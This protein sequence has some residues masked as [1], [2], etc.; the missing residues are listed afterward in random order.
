MNSKRILLLSLSPPKSGTE[1]QLHKIALFLKSEGFHVGIISSK[2]IH[3]FGL[4]PSEKGIET[5]FLNSWIRHPFSNLWKL[6][7]AIKT[8]RPDVVLAFMFI[9][10]IVARLMKI[11]LRF[12]LI[13]TIRMSVINRKWYLPFIMTSRLDDAV[14]YNSKASKYNFERKKLVKKRGTVIHNGVQLP[15]LKPFF[16]TERV[17]FTWV[18]IGHFR[19][20]KDYETL[21]KAMLLLRDMPEMKGKRFRL[22]VI[23]ELYEQ[24]WPYEM[25]NKLRINAHVNLLGFKQDIGEYLHEADAV[26]LSSH[27][28]GMPNAILEAMAQAKP[29]VATA[30][31]GNNE[32]LEAARCGYLSE[33]KNAEHLATRMLKMMNLTPTERHHL[34]QNGRRYIASNF[35]EPLVMEQWKALIN[36][37][38]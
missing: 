36:Q 32:L 5:L 15:P 6:R 37:Q 13:S 18:C 31:D 34:G 16:P 10:I 28:E 21:F 29:I 20:N 24:I 7:R 4:N 35:N 12:K 27:S 8:F 2:Q 30:I 9:A 22:K 33:K 38:V 25:I 19:W 23:G 11:G 3:E 26:V 1:T 17:T 14:V